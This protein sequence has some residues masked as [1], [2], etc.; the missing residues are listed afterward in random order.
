MTVSN[1]DKSDMMSF[2]SVMNDDN[3]EMLPAIPASNELM[4]GVDPKLGQIDEA[5]SNKA[6]LNVMNIFND[7]VGDDDNFKDN[8]V[9][10]FRNATNMV[11]EDANSDRYLEKAIKTTKTS[12]GFIYG[13]Y[14]LLER[15]QQ[16][17]RSYFSIRHNGTGET[18]VKDLYLK[19]SALSIVSMLNEGMPINNQRC[20]QALNM[21]AKYASALVDMTQAKKG[22]KRGST[23][24]EDR[25]DSAK[26]KA[27][28]AKTTVKRLMESFQ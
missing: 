10:S 17:K 4:E 7:A 5:A 1:E 28:Q 14:E 26:Q 6:M 22:M 24:S 18:L 12:T 2:M 8:V 15:K 9:E 20:L 11:K 19:E 21:D 25:Y 13:E 3:N 23:L 27:I 16:N